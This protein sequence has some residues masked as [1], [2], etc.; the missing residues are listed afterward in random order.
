MQISIQELSR[1]LRSQGI[2]PINGKRA[3]GNGK[4]AGENGHG[5]AASIQLSEQAQEIQQIK[6]LV[7]ESPD[8]REDLVQQLKA[9]YEA[10][11]YHVSGEDI[12]ELAIRR[13]FADNIK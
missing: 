1:V 4:A 5:P 2:S 6:K 13:A 3:N 11:S 8:V 9:K 7:E 12:A 10:G